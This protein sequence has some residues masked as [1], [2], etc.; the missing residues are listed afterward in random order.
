MR[1]CIILLILINCLFAHSISTLSQRQIEILNKVYKIAKTVPNNKGETFEKTAMA[2]CFTETSAGLMKV[3]DIREDANIFNASLGV[4]QMRIETVK[5]MGKRLNIKE[6]TSKDDVQL[7]NSL[8][9]DND[10]NIRMAVTFIVWMNNRF[11]QNYFKT[12]SRYNGGNRNWTYY[13][14]VMKNMR[15]IKKWYKL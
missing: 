11:G 2:I 15:L 14:K 13:R 12:I 6:I 3:G 9:A 8:L 5:H 10:F 1:V 4:M 7:V